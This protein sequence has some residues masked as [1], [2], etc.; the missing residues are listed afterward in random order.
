MKPSLIYDS[1]ALL[2]FY[3][4]SDSN[5]LN[6]MRREVQNKPYFYS[7]VPQ[8]IFVRSFDYTSIT[9]QVVQISSW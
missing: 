5:I 8:I 7:Q 2:S 3:L 9:A 6:N 4:N 1:A